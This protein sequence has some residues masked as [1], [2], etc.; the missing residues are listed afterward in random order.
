MISVF[1]RLVTMPMYAYLLLG[2]LFF[3]VGYAWGKNFWISSS[4]ATT[5][6]TA[7]PKSEP[8]PTGRHRLR[9]AAPGEEEP[10]SGGMLRVETAYMKQAP[11]VSTRILDWAYPDGDQVRTSN[12]GS[13]IAFIIPETIMPGK[14]P[15]QFIEHGPDA[16]EHF[17]SG[18]ENVWRVGNGEASSITD[19]DDE[20]TLSHIEF[21]GLTVDVTLVDDPSVDATIDWGDGTEDATRSHTYDRSGLYLIQVLASATN[22]GS[23]TSEAYIYVQEP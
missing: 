3:F 18:Q 14:G 10:M 8:T 16:L 21:A 23:A 4:E 20:P 11:H 5:T 1:S 17:K 15:L 13:G 12:M 22:D 19:P 6:T 7:R 2:V 9:P